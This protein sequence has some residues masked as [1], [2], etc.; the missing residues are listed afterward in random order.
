MNHFL[1]RMILPS[2]SLIRT[3]PE[4]YFVSCWPLEYT[5]FIVPSG[6]S[7][8]LNC[9]VW[10]SFCPLL[11]ITILSPFLKKMTITKA[12]IYV[13]KPKFPHGCI[14][15]PDRD[16]G[17]G[18]Y[19]VGRLQQVAAETNAEGQDCLRSGQHW[20]G[21]RRGICW[22]NTFQKLLWTVGLWWS[23]SLNI[24]LLPASESY[25]KGETT[26]MLPKMNPPYGVWARVGARTHN[27][28]LLVPRWVKVAQMLYMLRQ[29]MGRVNRNALL[30]LNVLMNRS[31]LQQW[32][33]NITCQME[34]FPPSFSTAL[35]FNHPNVIA[36]TE[37]L[38]FSAVLIM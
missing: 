7:L 16:P 11:N 19:T 5:V 13:Q 20:I 30:R 31:D 22:I 1:S 10:I 25:K 3:R 9:D 12:F 28:H 26:I 24:K 23:P 38:W 33:W 37:G 8:L 17:S 18:K 14:V 27:W 21:K 34:A 2:S 32:E 6:Y 29:E 15:Y 36:F 35:I 4:E